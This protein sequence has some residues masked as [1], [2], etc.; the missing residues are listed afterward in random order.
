M[1]CLIGCAICSF[2][3]KSTVMCVPAPAGL[4]APAAASCDRHIWELNTDKVDI[5]KENWVVVN[6]S[7]APP[8][9]QVHSLLALALLTPCRTARLRTKCTVSPGRSGVLCSVA[10]LHIRTMCRDNTCCV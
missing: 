1:I 9:V 7:K 10:R 6:T 2:V 4:H 3:A 8:T 5:V